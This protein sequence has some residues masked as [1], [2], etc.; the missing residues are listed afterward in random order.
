MLT[1]GSALREYGFE[2]PFFDVHVLLPDRRRVQSRDFVRVERTTRLPEPEMRNGLP[3]APIERAVLDSARRAGAL[4]RARAIIATVV[5]RGATTVAALEA[6]LAEGSKRGAA[7]PRAVLAEVDAEV[8]SVPEIE[9]REL[10]VQSGLPEMVFNVDILDYEGRFIA[11]PDGWIDSVAFAW[12]IDSV[13]WHLSP[14]LYSETIEKRTLMQSHGII[15]LATT[16]Q[17]VRKTPQRVIRDLE[18]HFELAQQRPRPNVAARIP[19]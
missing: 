5:Q 7:L 3:C 14:K 18:A 15:V 11:R 1:G 2:E 4:N 16:P 6:E 9:A 13:A 12:Q 17:S 8:H 19:R 10:W